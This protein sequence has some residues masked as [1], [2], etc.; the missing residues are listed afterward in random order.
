ML[1]HD[2]HQTHIGNKNA[3][4]CSETRASINLDNGWTYTDP[5][6]ESASLSADWDPLLGEPEIKY[7]GIIITFGFRSIFFQ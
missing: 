5:N 2:A 4:C 3:V 6:D 7:S 1:K